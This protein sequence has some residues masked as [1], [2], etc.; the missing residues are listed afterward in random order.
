M[1]RTDVLP[2]YNHDL[3]GFA[4]VLRTAVFSSQG[5]AAEHFLLN[6]STIVRYEN[7]ELKPP[8]GYLACL[9]RLVVEKRHSP[10]TERHK[11][12]MQ[13]NRA[14]QSQYQDVPFQTWPELI[15]V[16]DSYLAERRQSAAQPKTTSSHSQTPSSPP[17]PPRPVEA[18][19]LPVF[20]TERPIEQKQLLQQIKAGNVPKLVLWGAAGVGKSVLMAW[21]A[22]NVGDNFPDGQIWVE[23]PEDVSAQAAV[24][25]VQLHI[26]RSLGVVLPGRSLADRA[27]Q[28][29][30]LLTEK[31]YLL[32]IDNV[33]LTTELSHLQV[34]GPTGCLL[35]TTRYRKVADVLESP[36]LQIKGMSPSEGLTLLLRW[37]EV[38]A[39]EADKIDGLVDRLGGLPLALKLCGARLREGETVTQLHSYFAQDNIDL[40]QLDL[41]DPQTPHDSLGR[42]FERSLAHLAQPDQQGFIQLGCFSG[43]FEAKDSVAIWAI[44]FKEA[45]RRLRR[46]Y[47]LALLKRDGVIYQLHPLLRDYTRQKLAVIP[48]DQHN[49]YRRHA[50]YYI[51][52][53]LYH[54]QLG[55]DDAPA[56]PDLSQSWV[57]IVAAVK[58][59][60]AHDPELAAMAAWLAYVDRPALIEAVGMPL[61]QAVATY[62]NQAEMAYQAVWHELLGDL[63]LLIEQPEAALVTFTQA[64]QLWQA[65]QNHL[66]ASRTKLRLAG[67]QLILGHQLFAL[68]AIHQAQTAL[69]NSLPLDATT[70]P[71]VNNLFYWFNLISYSVMRQWPGSLPEAEIKQLVKLTQS[72]Q[73]PLLEA[74]AWHIYRL[75]CTVN[76]QPQ[77][78]QQQGRQFGARAA[79]LW[80]RHGRK[81]K[82]LA[83]VMWTQEHTR[84][85]RS[86]RL[87]R[88][89][90]R[91]RS[92]GTPLLNQNQIQLIDNEKI[93]Y[94]L[95]ATKAERIEWLINEMPPPNSDDWQAI[96]ELLA[97]GI[98]GQ[99]VRRL[100]KGI[101]PPAE[102]TVGQAVWRAM[103]GQ[104]VLAP[105]EPA[106]TELT[107]HC[108]VR[109]GKITSS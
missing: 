76:P 32:M 62:A 102:V 58:W 10:E 92:Q 103:T 43:R 90:A 45:Q 3:A 51:R 26:A 53:Y 24:S 33:T 25:E 74:Q 86:L 22:A 1:L 31:R 41:D 57:D 49:T 59:A 35:S 81:D 93:R 105:S 50:A 65:K 72:I 84:G 18:P 80:W 94:W 40:S 44:P 71:V 88:H 95:A 67:V 66:A 89:F 56:A 75:W 5:R 106:A 109:L 28:L 46:L 29:R 4:G 60:A 55:D 21:L 78:I 63:Y 7:E 97:L 61:V 38:A 70:Q 68:E 73:Q 64:N 108:L 15:A 9:V 85:R 6:R 27:A 96:D 54:P 87:A 2:T 100:A 79:W 101:A 107:R 14:I 20:Y 19:A 99:G 83:E 12:L 82:A 30:T 47:S 104:K 77:A 37:A 52:H 16:T 91:R 8:L 17:T 34:T 39:E 23:L 11:L 36:L 42:C 48:T 69:A 98:L 13:L